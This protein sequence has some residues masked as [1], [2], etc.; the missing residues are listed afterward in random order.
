MY[1]EVVLCDEL[2][3]L[4]HR[5]RSVLDWNS[6]LGD[7]LLEQTIEGKHFVTTADGLNLPFEEHDIVEFVDVGHDAR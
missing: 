4:H 5:C 7:V 2:F 6:P 3:E 1:L